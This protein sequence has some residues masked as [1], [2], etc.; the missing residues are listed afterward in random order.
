VALSGKV[1]LSVYKYYAKSI[2]YAVVAVV[3][4]LYGTEQG[5]RTGANVWL[6]HWSDFIFYIFLH[7]HFLQLQHFFPAI[8]SFFRVGKWSC[9]GVKALKG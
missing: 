7:L 3:L 8:P 4:A 1:N 9:P 5:F 6:R 2:G